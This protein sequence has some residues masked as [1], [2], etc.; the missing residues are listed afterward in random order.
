MIKDIWENVKAI[1]MVLFAIFTTIA[2]LFM[3]YFTDAFFMVTKNKADAR[4]TLDQME[5]AVKVI[6]NQSELVKKIG[7]E[8]GPIVYLV[9]APMC[10]LHRAILH[11]TTKRIRRFKE[12]NA[13]S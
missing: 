9:K 6:S 12:M 2:V 5:Q 7:V 3:Y 13:L 8:H 11:I 10:F 4:M 1:P